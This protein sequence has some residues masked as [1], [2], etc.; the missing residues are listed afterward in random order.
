MQLSLSFVQE[1]LIRPSTPWSQ[2]NDAEQRAA[3]EVLARLL[4]QAAVTQ[5]NEEHDHDRSE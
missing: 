3:I 2:L 1:A 5:P 4:A